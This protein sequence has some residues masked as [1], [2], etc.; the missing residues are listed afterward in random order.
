[1]ARKRRLIA[2]LPPTP[3]TPELRQSVVKRADAEGVS[4]ADVTRQ[5][6]TLFLANSVTKS[7]GNVPKCDNSRQDAS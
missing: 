1:M 4:I 7:N 6:L 3:C 2:S 5:A